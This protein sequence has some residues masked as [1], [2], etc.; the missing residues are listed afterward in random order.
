MNK[1]R[2]N[3]SLG[4]SLLD[5]NN[6][7][8][9][10]TDDDLSQ[11]FNIA[12]ERYDAFVTKDSLGT[13]VNA[14]PV[15]IAAPAPVNAPIMSSQTGL[16]AA[17]A[18]AALTGTGTVS[19]TAIG[20]AVT[21]DFDTLANTGTSSSLPTG[22]YFDE[23]GT[24]NNLLYSAGTGSGTSGDTYS[25]GAASST[26]RA[27][28]TLQ[29]GS[30]TPTIGAQFTNST[31]S[32]IG[33]L[34]FAYVGEQWRLGALSR[35]DS[36]NFQISFD[37]TNL[38][39]GTWAN[40]TQ[41]TFTA[42]T[43]TGT[44]GLLNGNLAANQ[45][46]ISYSLMLAT[47]IASGQSFWIRWTDTNPTGSDDGLGIDNF[48]ITAQAAV[49]V[50]GTLAIND[51]A[52]AEGNAGTTNISFTVTRSGGSSG[53]VSATWTLANDTSD[54]ADFTS[55]PQ[56]GT[57]NFADGQTSAT[58][59][60]AVAGDVIVET[61]ETFF[62]NLTAPTGGATISDAQG[63]G[64]INNDDTPPVGTLSINDV[65]VAEGNA[66]TTNLVFT[67]TRSAGSFGPAAATWTVANGTTN[68]ADFSGALTGTVSFAD[69][70]TT[71]TVTVAV[72][73]DTAFEAN[74]TFTVSLTAPTGGVTIS[75]ASGIGTITNDDAPPAIAN[76]WINEF[77]YDPAGADTNE[78]IE[79]AGLAGTDLT[80]WSLLLYNG[81]GGAVY[82]TY[83]LT[84]A[85]TN[86]S[87]GFGFVRVLTPGIQNGAPD[88][89][90][91]VDNLGRVVQFLSYEGT[92]TAV[93]GA[94]NGMTSINVGVEQ[95]NAALGFTLQLTGTGSS[96]GDFTWT[97]N[98]ANTE[99]AVNGGQT[100]L[101]G[102]DQGQLRVA[103]ASVTEG[104]TGVTNLIFT[105]YRAGGYASSA[106]VNYEVLLTGT[107]DGDDFDADTVFA[108][109]ITFAANEYSRTIT[110]RVAGDVVGEGNETLFVQLSNVTGNAVIT[111]GSATGTII[112]DDPVS[113]TIMQIQGA[114][115]TSAFAG[116]QVITGGIV[117]A[118]DTDG[119]YMQHATGDGNS[120]TSDGIFVFTT[121]PPTV[122]VG[123]AVSVSGTVQEFL[124]G[125]NPQ[126]LTVTRIVP[127][128]V[129]VDSSGNALPAAVLIGTGGILPP[130]EAYE[131]DGFT[132]FN[133]TVD[134]LDFYE[135]LEGMRVTIDAPLVVGPTNSFG[136]TTVVASGGVGVTGVNS[137]GGITISAG[138]FNPERIQID[139]DSGLF[140][141]YP[142]NYT[143]GDRLSSVTGVVS[144]NFTSYEVL[145]T[146]AVTITLDAP[147]LVRN[148][149]MLAGD[150]D[151]L[152]MATYN[153]SNLD[154]TD[155]TF[156]LLAND[157]V[158][159]LG[160]PD[161]LAAQEIQDADGA[162]S[163]SNLSGTVTAQLL[164]D[165]IVAAGGPRYMYI[166]VAPT[167]AN[168]SGGEPNGNIRTG[169]F[170]NPDRVSY[171]AGS[172]TAIEGSAYN[173]TRRPLAAQF[174]F[175]GQ[176][177][178]AI[179]VHFTSRGGSDP[180]TGSIQ[181]PNNSGDAA[182]TAQAT[183]VAAYVNSQ[184]AT[185]PNL[186]VAVLGDFNGFWFENAV[187][188]L[189]TTAGLNRASDLAPEEERYS[190]VFDN[191][192]QQIDHILLSNRLFAGA[193]YD[194]VHINAE[195]S[196]ASRPSDHDPQVVLLLIPAPNAAPTA[197]V[198][199]NNDINE[200]NAVGAVIGTV[201]ATDR[202][203]DVLTYS[204]SDDADGRFVINAIT[205]VLSATGQLDYEAAM[206]H[207]VTVRVTDQ[208]GLFT[209]LSIAINV[210]NVN[211]A[212]S[213]IANAVSLD[214]DASSSNL[215]TLL[216]GNDFDPDAGDTL[217]ITTTGGTA[218]GT[219]QFDAVTQSLVYI[220]DNNAFDPLRVGESATDSFTYTI[221]DANGLTSTATVTVTVN[222]VADA[223]ISQ[224]GTILDDILNGADGNDTF[225]ALAGNDIVNGGGSVDT[226]N[227]DAGNDRLILGSAASGSSIDGGADTDT[228]VITRTVTSLAGLIGI[229]SLELNGG[230]GLTITGT[231]FANGLALTTA[232]SGTGSITVNM[233]AG[234]NF[235][236]QGFAFAGS[237][238]TVNVNGT[239]GNDVIK[240]GSGV[241]IINAG[242][243]NDQIRG[244]TS[245]DIING[246][247]GIDKIIGNL[248]ADIITGGAGNDQFRYFR[249]IESG[250]G[251]LADTITDY[252]IGVDRFNF[253]AFDTNPGLDGIQGFA[254]VGNA[255]FSGGGA[256]QLRYTNSGADLLVQADVNGDGIA[257][258]E[259]IL[260]GQAGGTLTA[261]DFIL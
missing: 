49:A 187:G 156:N 97:A 166:E 117:T 163:G 225:N 102:T 208:G 177:I 207:I 44:V 2:H 202:V 204:L 196:A 247:A 236:S 85:L 149:T 220:A 54:N 17:P 170:Y 186:N 86:A 20:T 92:M 4:N 41:L 168:T 130:T 218:L 142:P 257:D 188:T 71:A 155:T 95:N 255:A 70:Q 37:A 256:A 48:S 217:T 9:L 224:T 213:A 84:G 93:G 165:A 230:A 157:I 25:F 191:N 134:G 79:I 181:P 75:D 231:Q 135:S 80:G 174:T 3:F 182:R 195:F 32:S 74:E 76:V 193:Q 65:T 106:S 238:V 215:Y 249:D 129:V 228:L 244:G 50:P 46:A 124:A 190:Y 27:F 227:G 144:Y 60:I 254:F 151:H 259:I 26:E 78:F 64:T 253:S 113:L 18:P 61:N 237:G 63:V 241:H 115:H 248:G 197:V 105:V 114:S 214:E 185:N 192:A 22:W 24:A 158:Y 199:S 109:T 138:D 10:N 210:D 198:I 96:Y 8:S 6:S 243:G 91:L 39:T 90:A 133:P 111:D 221:R 200:N 161:I 14:A 12:E 240:C 116:Q 233:D 81:N 150:A 13:F 67:V 58:V 69:G 51:V 38:T 222:G 57:V 131:S 16:I 136:E 260:Q 89:F 29:S 194:A 216:L 123:D 205:G 7:Q 252:E 47:A 122:T 183:G 189:V 180:L 229:E 21:Q 171:V 148:P 121:T 120:A 77:N 72:S 147:A 52:L 35:A 172:A 239:S 176:T 175:N 59:T 108:G 11:I 15:F 99:A 162:G 261:A 110:V 119:F 31:G 235:L 40:V 137:R 101:S 209:E 66:G 33:S 160:A 153:L 68:A 179:D 83:T 126:N 42:P 98:V 226:L 167:V 169:F 53:A 146:E 55:T 234:I 23:V 178:L 87:N 184:L 62:V 100:F 211:E 164:I 141:G 219:V 104:N 112:N 88:G 212:P 73:G 127:A 242:D 154:P 45:T 94:A 159:A 232:V 223:P 30:N 28:G 125:A 250:L 1:I 132:V 128:S 139:D 258:M 19:L 203:G 103:D 36:L 173:G 107:A 245:D 82:A 118:V 56:T 5:K 145:V 201:S 152:S 43:Q 34:D 246:G 251:A 143:Q 140:A 206:V